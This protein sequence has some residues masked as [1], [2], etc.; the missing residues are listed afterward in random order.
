M[1]V[2]FRILFI[3]WFLQVLFFEQVRSASSG[4][5]GVSTMPS[6]IRALMG[7]ESSDER[8][9]S[10]MH[11]ENVPSVSAS[12]DG[13]YVL[14]QDF[15]CLKDELVSLKTRIAE[16]ENR[17]SFA[18]D[19]LKPAHRKSIFAKPKKFWQKLFNKKVSNSASSKDMDSETQSVRES[20][21]AMLRRRHSMMA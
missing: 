3:L 17:T 19:S 8:S 18:H 12:A 7:H 21:T 4:G 5:Y 6:N 1:Q 16:A 14:H 9:C 20:T 13:G 11:T 10:D 15:S 2:D